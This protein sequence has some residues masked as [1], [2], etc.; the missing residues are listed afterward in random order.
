MYV[1]GSWLRYDESLARMEAEFQV[2]DQTGLT[3]ITSSKAGSTE[4]YS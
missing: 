3:T 1:H 2:V 4:Q